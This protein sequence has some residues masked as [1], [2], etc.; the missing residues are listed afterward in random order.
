MLEQI[1]RSLFLFINSH[2]SIFWDRIMYAVSGKA[3][4]IPLY[5]A[6]ITLIIIKYR[7]RAYILVPLIIVTVIITD[8]LSVH[9]FK[10][11]FMRLRP[12]REPTLEGM[13]HLV[14]G[15]CPGKWGFVSSHAANS[16]GVAIISLLLLRRRWFTIS[17]VAWASLI[18]YSRVYL[19]V[20]YPGDVICG[21]LLGIVVAYLVYGIYK[22]F[23][24]RFAIKK[25]ANS[26]ETINASD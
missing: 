22:E 15:K 16:F 3:I 14:N 24:K 23:D 26:K 5:I 20:H 18:G 21:S 11:V 13:V 6:I 1:D 8:Q 12:C 9:A 19:G 4:W 10:E 17:M 25:S 2:N 7:R